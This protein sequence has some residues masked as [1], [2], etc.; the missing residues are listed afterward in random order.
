MAKRATIVDVAARAGVAISSVSSALNGQPG[1]SESTRQRIRLAADELGFVPS[2]RGRSLSSKRAFSVGL[3]VERDPDVL[4]SDP[5]FGS[6]LGGIESVLSSRGY[7]L[8]LQMSDR[9][10]E[11]LDRYRRLSADRRVDG[12]FLSE[13]EIDDPRIALLEELQIPTVAINTDVAPFPFVSVRQ[14]HSAGIE[15][16][17]AYL[18]DLGHTQFAHISGPPHFIHAR[19]RESAWRAALVGL[20][21]TPG[22]VVEGDFTY[23]GGKRAA[24]VLL[25]GESSPTAVVCASDLMAVGFMTRAT[26]LGYSIP[27]DF[28]VTGYDGIR[29]GEYIRPRLTTLQTSPRRIGAEAARILL[30]EID[31]FGVRDVDIPPAELVVRESTGPAR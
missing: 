5:F 7:A 11:T 17:V 12:V 28:S 9:P 23:D 15:Q 19:Q 29:L 18:A 8:V 14:D 13:I 1:V 24:D 4:E 26:D 2:L 25:A 31:G 22:P 3:V 27:G 20:G 30:D 6:F 10:E 16:L 21:L